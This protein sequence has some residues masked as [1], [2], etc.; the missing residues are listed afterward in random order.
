MTPSCNIS[1]CTKPVLQKFG[2]PI[3]SVGNGVLAVY[4]SIEHNQNT[5]LTLPPHEIALREM[6]VHFYRWKYYGGEF[7][8]IIAA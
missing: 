7:L 5:T 6:M 1:N 2:A 4:I 8:G 3:P